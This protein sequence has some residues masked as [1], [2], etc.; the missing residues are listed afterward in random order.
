MLHDRGLF[1]GT[2]ASRMYPA[3]PTRYQVFYEHPH[4][5]L[6]AEEHQETNHS[7]AE[8]MLLLLP[9]NITT[10]GPFYN[11][12]RWLIAKKLYSLIRNELLREDETDWG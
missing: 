8:L 5:G 2:V 4:A 10:Q 6:I 11:S 3:D 12:S 7:E 1:L 9:Q